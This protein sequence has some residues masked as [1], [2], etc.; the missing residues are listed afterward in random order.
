MLYTNHV[1]RLSNFLLYSALI[2]LGVS[3][4]A[5]TSTAPQSTAPEESGLVKQVVQLGGFATPTPNNAPDFIA[6]SRPAQTEYVPVGTS[7]PAR[8][9]RAKTAA[10]VEKAKADLNQT[11]STNEAQGESAKT[12]GTSAAPEPSNPQLRP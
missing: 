1:T 2:C 4:G 6:T 3:V 11:R 7:A 8:P 9:V 5:C 12:L 10:E